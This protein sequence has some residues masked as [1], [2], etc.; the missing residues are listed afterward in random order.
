MFVC[1]SF[2]D[3]VCSVVFVYVVCVLCQA[4]AATP[5]Q[6]A[7]DDAIAE[8]TAQ[9]VLG[10]D[11][12]PF[13]LKRVNELTKGASLIANIALIKNNARIGAQ[14]AAELA[15][16]P[17]DSV[18]ALSSSSGVGA[19]PVAATSSSSSSSTAAVTSWTPGQSSALAATVCIVGGNAQVQT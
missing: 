16:L 13:L 12:T 11:V 2:V 1:A 4:A 10:R 5:L 14:I 8:A 19:Q 3:L 17:S 15:R 18:R 6:R 9:G 7:Q